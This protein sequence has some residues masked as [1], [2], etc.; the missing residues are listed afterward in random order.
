M[1]SSSFCSSSDEEN[2]EEHYV[3]SLCNFA[4]DDDLSR[5]LKPHM[6]FSQNTANFPA[7]QIKKQ[8]KTK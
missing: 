4:Q 1:I 8:T 7:I 5:L 3:S 6:M 2:K